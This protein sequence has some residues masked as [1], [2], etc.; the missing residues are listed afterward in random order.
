MITVNI[1]NKIYKLNDAATVD[2]ALDSV[3]GLRKQGIAVA[4]NMEVLPASK[5][6]RPLH[7]GDNIT[8]IK[9]FYGG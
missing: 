4:V 1:N 2:D 7:D 9:A 3:E 5:W 6:N 8:I